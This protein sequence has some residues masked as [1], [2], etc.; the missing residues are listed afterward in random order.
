MQG[1]EGAKVEGRM[2]TF[3]MIYN[4]Q[5]RDPTEESLSKPCDGVRYLAGLYGLEELGLQL[6]RQGARS[7]WTRPS[8][9][10]P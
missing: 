4:P 2:V 3:G 8:S 7:A 1:P 10:S 5:P 6:R 9:G